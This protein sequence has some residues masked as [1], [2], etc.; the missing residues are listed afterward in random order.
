MWQYFS[1]SFQYFRGSLL[2]ERV[3]YRGIGGQHHLETRSA[4]IQ[5]L[6]GTSSLTQC[7]ISELSK[8]LFLRNE[9]SQIN[10][11][12]PKCQKNI[13]TFWVSENLVSG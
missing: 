7:K 3:V 4:V 8:A 1:D 12:S 6:K 13:Y 9:I 10:K 11:F 5:A 2:V